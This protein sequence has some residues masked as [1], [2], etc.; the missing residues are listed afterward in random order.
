MDKLFQMLA[1]LGS[2]IE[3]DA[4]L[5]K[6]MKHEATSVPVDKWSCLTKKLFNILPYA[7]TSGQLD[8]ISEIIWDLRRPI[9]MNRLLQVEYV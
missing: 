1:A 5:E 8:A 2:G 4:L 7:L 9:P 6:Y 3:K